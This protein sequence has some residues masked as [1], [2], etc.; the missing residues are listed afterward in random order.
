MPLLKSRCSCGNRVE[1]VPITPPG[2][3]RPAFEFD[4]KMIGEVIEKQ[5]G[6]CYM[7]EVVLLNATPAIDRNDESIRDGR[8]AGSF[9]YDKWAKKFKFQPRPWKASL[10]EIKKG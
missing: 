3:V 5:F 4:K 10:C 2:D 7:P 8:G 1:K 9:F 6:S